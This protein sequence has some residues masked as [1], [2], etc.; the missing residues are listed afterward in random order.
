MTG[1]PTQKSLTEHISSETRKNVV[2]NV[3]LNVSIAYAMLHSLAQVG[4]WGEHGYVKD[5]ILTGFLLSALLGGIFIAMHRRK[6]DRQEFLLQGDEGQTLARFIPYN[7][8]L[9]ATWLGI[10]GAVVAAPFLIGLFILI[11]IE[12]LTP[13]AYALI[14]GIWAGNL[15]AIIVPIAIRQG[16]RT[17][18]Q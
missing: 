2:I 16:L 13:L 11:G 6:R 10:L 18:P 8:W 3:I 9:A 12:L 17:A 4:A 1:E 14:K 5:L 7:P 15:A